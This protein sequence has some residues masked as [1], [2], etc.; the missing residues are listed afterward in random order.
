MD[1]GNLARVIRE[2]QQKVDV[3]PVAGRIFFRVA[4]DENDMVGFEVVAGRPA[5]IDGF[6]RALSGSRPRFRLSSGCPR[7]GDKGMQYIRKKR[8]YI[9]KVCGHTI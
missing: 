5:D 7:C 8:E 1:D 2:L 6:T 4:F 9:C 3:S